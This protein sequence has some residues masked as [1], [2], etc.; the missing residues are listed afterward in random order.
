M[1]PE[2]SII[3]PIYNCEKYVK[4][5]LNSLVSQSFSNV[6][7]ICIDDAS[8]DGTASIAK[9]FARTNNNIVFVGLQKNQGVAHTRNV[10]LKY[11]KGKYIMFCDGDDIYDTDMCNIMVNT[12]SDSE[13]DFAIAQIQLKYEDTSNIWVKESDEKY[14]ELKFRGKQ[15][16]SNK[17]ILDLDVSV[18]NKIFRRDI[19]DKY[20]ISFP[21][22]LLYEDTYFTLAY[23]FVSKNCFFVNRPLYTYIR[24]ENSIMDTTF[25]GK[26]NALDH[27][28]TAFNLYYFLKKNALV[29]SYKSLYPQILSSYYALAIRYSPKSEYRKVFDT[30]KN[31]VDKNDLLREFHNA[32]FITQIYNNGLYAPLSFAQKIFS[33]KNSLDGTRKR[34]T[35]LGMQFITRRK[36][37]K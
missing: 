25:S 7:I 13:I 2:V 27:L 19:I 16:I 17:L 24:H 5:T 22:G 23:T 8:T 26:A 4:D 12:M 36:Q 14:Y 11:A 29:E 20:D 33:I 34:I 35:F 6:Q 37:K 28:F 18:C 32:P 10:G 30:Y 3:V 15:P 31:F 9:E 1:T 21:E